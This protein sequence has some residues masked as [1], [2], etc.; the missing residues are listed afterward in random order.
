MAQRKGAW[1]FIPAAVSTARALTK[2]DT[3]I[4]IAPPAAA[5]P[6]RFTPAQPAR[7][8]SKALKYVRLIDAQ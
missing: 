3:G 8:L 4:M 5:A 6:V 7:S 2:S 1:V